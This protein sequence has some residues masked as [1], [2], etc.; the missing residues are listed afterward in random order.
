MKQKFP[1]KEGKIMYFYK[2]TN[3]V[4]TTFKK[5]LN[6]FKFNNG[7]LE[8]HYP[9]GS[10]Y[11]FYTN[12]LRRKISKNGTEEIFN[13]EELEKSEEKK[14]KNLMLDDN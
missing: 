5:G 3:T 13:P 2:E 8:K 1:G 7:Q 10:K 6:V 12:G 9:D 11:I 4:E 14:N